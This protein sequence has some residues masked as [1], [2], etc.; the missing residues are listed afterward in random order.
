[1]NEVFAFR[2]QKPTEQLE[3]HIDMR[4][5][6][7]LRPPLNQRRTRSILEHAE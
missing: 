7:R 6:R 3:L 2:A 1:M 5:L 4:R